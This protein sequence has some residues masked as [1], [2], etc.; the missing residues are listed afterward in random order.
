MMMQT[1]PEV[2]VAPIPAAVA[3]GLSLVFT[4]GVWQYDRGPSSAHRAVTAAMAAVSLLTLF[5]TFGLR[6]R[7]HRRELLL[8]TTGLLFSAAGIVLM[9]I[10]AYLDAGPVAVVLAAVTT[11]LLFL[12][13]TYSVYNM[14]ESP[15]AR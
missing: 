11:L 13:S 9:L 15:S 8:R 1:E 4:V 12:L 6:F 7:S 2:A 5:V 10:L 14:A 3:L